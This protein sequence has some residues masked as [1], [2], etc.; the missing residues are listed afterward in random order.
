MTSIVAHNV[1][2]WY[3]KHHALHDITLTMPNQQVTALMGPS[4]C[5]KSTFIRTLNR[6][7]EEI[8]GT[9]VTGEIRVNDVNLY[10]GRITAQYVRRHIGMVFQRPNVLPA[11]SIYENVAI[12]LQINGIA[13]GK[14]LRER[15]QQSLH[16]AFL[17]DEVKD[18]LDDPAAGLSGGQQQR[19][20]IA[21]ALALEPQV[22]LLDEPTSAL[23]P[24]STLQVEDLVRHLKAQYTVVIV[25]HNLQQA[26]RIADQT[27]F[28][29]LGRI[30]EAGPTEQVFARPQHKETEDYITGRFG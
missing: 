25:T 26:T 21:R 17:W 1:N 12:G 28:F 19:L 9:R 11:R 15:V 3:G 13:R 5:G 6:M 16:Q 20:C 18:R 2:A 14:A 8:P 27:A 29:L 22:L 23:D 7:H 10:G 30:I 4:G 24:L